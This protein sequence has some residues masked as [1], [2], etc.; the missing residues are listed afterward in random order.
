MIAC[1]QVLKRKQAGYGDILAWLDREM[2]KL[3]SRKE[4]DV[5]ALVKVVKESRVG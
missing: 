5:A 3:S 1:R 2:Q 4:L